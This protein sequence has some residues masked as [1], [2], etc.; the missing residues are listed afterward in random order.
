[1]INIRRAVALGNS[2][3]TRF[4]RRA[5]RAALRFHL[6]VP[7]PLGWLMLSAYNGVRGLYY[8]TY[9]L[10]V[11]EPLFKAACR[12]YGRNVRTGVFVHF[13]TGAGDLVVG[14]DVYLDGK[15]SFGFGARFAERPLLR[16]GSRTY[17][18]HSCSFTVSSRVT[19][20]DDCFIAGGCY[21]LDSPG[22]PLDPAR[23]L[24]HAPPDPEQVKPVTV[25]DNVWIG[26]QAMVMPGVTIG[27]GSVVA[28]RSVVTKDVPPYTLVGGAPARVLK[29]LARG[30]PAAP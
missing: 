29:A 9:R 12:S 20:G 17:V 5:Y 21:F 28:A 11:C 18:G 16:I 19:V 13:V 3:A 10:L 25:G 4:A 1:M 30:A 8:V 15:S 6:P 23:R 22:H 27:E 2:P 26:T 14:D 7:R 24:A